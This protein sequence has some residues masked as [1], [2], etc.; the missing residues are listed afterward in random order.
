MGQMFDGRK[1][2]E[3]DESQ[4]HHQNFPFQYFA[5]ELNSLRTPTCNIYGSC[6][7]AY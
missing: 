2:D 6:K 1:F 4:L 5:I 7:S 3:F